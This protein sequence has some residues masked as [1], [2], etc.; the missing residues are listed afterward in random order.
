MVFRRHILLT[1]VLCASACSD[2][3]APSTP[4]NLA[5]TTPLAGVGTA[6]QAVAPS[7]AVRVTDQY[8]RPVVGVTVSFVVESGGGSLSSPQAITD[9]SGIATIAA[10]VLGSAS[11]ANTVRASVPE[12][13]PVIFTVVGNAGAAA[14][15]EKVSGD[16]VSAMA[17]SEITPRPAVRVLDANGNPVAGVTIS[18]ESG[19]GRSTVT[20]AQQVTSETGTATV[21]SWRLTGR[22]GEYTLD[23]TAGNLRVTFRA[24]AFYG[25]AASLSVASGNNQVGRA[26]F[27]LN[28]H[29]E[30][31]VTD[32]N[33]NPAPG[34]EVVFSVTLGGG[35]VINPA[36]TT[37]Q[38]GA[39]AISEWI[40]GEPG[41]QSVT[42]TVSGLASVVFTAIATTPVPDGPAFALEDPSLDTSAGGSNRTEPPIYDLLSAHA[43]FI[44]DTLVTSWSFN[45]PVTPRTLSPHPAGLD[46]VIYIDANQDG[47]PTQQS[48][49]SGA[50][51]SIRPSGQGTVV[52]SGGGLITE[53]PATHAGN[54]LTV[55]I[56]MPR[57]AGDD[58]NLSIV[59]L[60]YSADAVSDRFPNAGAV[61]VSRP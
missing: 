7:P 35:T 39:A 44:S 61:S 2:A 38:T 13:A 46:F 34:T 16:G 55:R 3:T 25:P 57:L 59:A 4:A 5:A 31:I 23:A 17:G 58:G 60:F 10:W 47:Q 20:G 18:F 37:N 14:T 1:L 12:L 51:F 32:A 6:G 30:V 28:R 22:D 33:G 40:L 42:A 53:V 36:Q 29:L 54:I 50:D 8:D 48:P 19:A 43:E 24:T 45:V 26:G 52:L 21:G 41:P 56:P 9:S 11:G 15:L 27:D 49:Q